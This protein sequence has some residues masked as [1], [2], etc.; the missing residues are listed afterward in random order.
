MLKPKNALLVI[1]T[2]FVLFASSSRDKRISELER[3]M[4]E[5]GAYQKNQQFGAVYGP[6]AAPNY[7][8]S[9][10]VEP[11]FYK[12]TVAS[13]NF[14]CYQ[15]PSFSGGVQT[16]AGSYYAPLSFDWSPGVRIGFTKDDFYQQC[17]L[18]LT[19]TYFTTHTHLHKKKGL[20]SPFLGF[21]S[22]SQ[23]EVFSE[24]SYK[25]NFQNLDL[26][27][28]KGYFISEKIVFHTGVGLKGTYL[29]Q[30]EKN[31]N[32][33]SSRA[34]QLIFSSTELMRSRFSAVGPKINYASRWYLFKEMSL[35]SRGAASLLYGYYKI[36]NDFRSHEN[37][38]DLKGINRVS[39]KQ[40]FHSFSPY[41]EMSLGLSWNRAYYKEKIMLSL[42]VG[43][44]ALFFWRQ[45]KNFQGI[46]I[47]SNDSY[48]KESKTFFYCKKGEDISFRG[49]FIQ[50]EIDF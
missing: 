4:M 15:E 19:Y 33:L 7:R 50:S 34:Y 31:S 43:Y 24:G 40:D 42:S 21:S 9:I 35:F 36:S 18:A 3:Q 2:P 28:T 12:T 30:K 45:A 25:I 20:S 29:N 8:A 46:G 48:Q 10:K 39:V 5:V 14:V 47:I 23:P 11:F 26:D 13:S 41:A 16:G 49:L 17:S 44:D 37:G 6:A 38:K 22:F 27:L 32:N 1:L